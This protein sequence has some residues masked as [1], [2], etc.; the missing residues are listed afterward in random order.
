MK[1]D[2]DAMTVHRH[3]LNKNPC[4][5]AAEMVNCPARIVM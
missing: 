3:R 1:G 2:F 4:Q 5:F